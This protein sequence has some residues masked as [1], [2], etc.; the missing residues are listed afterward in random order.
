MR[1]VIKCEGVEHKYLLHVFIACLYLPR[2]SYGYSGESVSVR[3]CADEHV[4]DYVS[5]LVRLVRIIVR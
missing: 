5:L 2:S 4:L 3:V 1:K